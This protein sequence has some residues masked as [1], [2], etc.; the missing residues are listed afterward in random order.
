MAKWRANSVLAFVDQYIG[1]LRRYR[2][3]AIDIGDLDGLL[4][5]TTKL[6]EVL[7]SY[8][9]TNRFE[10]Y[11]GTHTSKMDVRFQNH[12]I[13]FFSQNLIFEVPNPNHQNCAAR[14]EIADINYPQEKWA[15][16][17]PEEV[18]LS[19][20][21]LEKLD[22]LIESFGG[23]SGLLLRHGKI[24]HTWGD[25]EKRYEVASCT[26]MLTST[27]MGL[28]VHDNKLALDDKICQYAPEITLPKDKKITIAH[29]LSMTSEYQRS[30]LP[31]EAWCYS[32][33]V[34]L[35]SPIIN[36]EY[37]MSMANFMRNRVLKPIGAM[38]WEWLSRETS[39]GTVFSYAGYGL[40]ISASDMAR[41]GFLYL[42]NGN[43]NGKNIIPEEWITLATHSSQRLKPVYGYLWWVNSAGDWPEVP[44]DSYCALG[45]GSRDILFV[46]P[47]MDLIAVRLGGESLGD[48]KNLPIFLK[49]V[50]DCVSKS[51]EGPEHGTGSLP[52]Q[53]N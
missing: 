45:A 25:I 41:L 35:L 12:V 21:Q 49:H 38:N 37:N 10:V 50:V 26:K 3:I 36:A 46:C 23:G 28:A 9:V 20:V 7:D 34:E 44:L 39:D 53:G 14:K 1:N 43:W 17:T 47:C 33:A 29:L 5:Q 40:N 16:V 51:S 11:S 22:A 6:H 27:A 8:G 52:G 19:A 42:N 18:G 32:G 2:A 24:A 48:T 15:L 13:P 31:G 4:E 30:G